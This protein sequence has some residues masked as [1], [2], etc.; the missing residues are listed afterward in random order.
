[1]RASLSNTS[2]AATPLSKADGFANGATS[3][4]SQAQTK[5]QRQNAAKTQAK[6]LEKEAMEVERLARLAQHKREVEAQRIKEFYK[7]QTIPSK[8]FSTHSQ[9]V[10]PS[11]KVISKASVNEKGSL[12]WD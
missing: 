1:M 9:S 3:A 7:K 10:P 4:A 5:R 11:A 8:P 6:K 2:K 12:V